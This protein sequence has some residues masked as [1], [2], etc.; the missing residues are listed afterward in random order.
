[1]SVATW[2]HDDGT[3]AASISNTTDPSGLVIRLSRRSH[4]TE[5][6]GSSPAVVNFRWTWSP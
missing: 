5:S 4:S 6:N 1:M 3:S 2:D